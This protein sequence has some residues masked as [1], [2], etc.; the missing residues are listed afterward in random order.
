MA[1]RSDH[2]RQELSTLI[3]DAARQIIQEK[4]VSG[5]STRKIADRIGYTVGTLYHVFI[6]ID[7][8]LAQ[9]NA[10]TLEDLSEKLILSV[11]SED[12][13]IC[14][15][16]S[17]AHTYI[18]FSYHNHNLWALLFEYKL[19]K[20]PL[21]DWYRERMQN[22]LMLLNALVAKVIRDDG[23]N[24]NLISNMFWSYLHGICAITQSKKSLDSE[25]LLDL[26]LEMADLF[27]EK[28]LL[29]MALS[30]QN[31]VISRAS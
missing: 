24:I 30:K 31:A 23:V 13:S 22:F 19:K 1:R 15:L 18:T 25:Y 27:M 3:L 2:T 17:L 28:L 10:N 11:R 8:I 5:L 9:I 26:N 29:V 12:A 14:A 20:E 4:G 21:P 7:D 6:N 16:K